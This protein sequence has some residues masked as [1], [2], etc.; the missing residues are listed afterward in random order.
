M[1]IT[2]ELAAQMYGV[3][4]RTAER[5]DA[6]GLNKCADYARSLANQLFTDGESFNDSIYQTRCRRRSTRR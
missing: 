5:Y 3:L 6:E 1:E 4:R 2:L